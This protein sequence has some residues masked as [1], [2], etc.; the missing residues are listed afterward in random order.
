MPLFLLGDLQSVSAGTNLTGSQAPV[1][2]SA[3]PDLAAYLSPKA[4]SA[5]LPDPRP[6]AES[7]SSQGVSSASTVAT[8]VGNG[9]AS[10]V[11]IFTAPRLP[12]GFDMAKPVSPASA[13]LSSVG[14]TFASVLGF[15]N[16]AAKSAGAN[17]PSAPLAPPV[18]TALFDFDGDGKTDAANWNQSTG[19]WRVKKSSDSSVYTLTFGANASNVV[20]GD[21]DGDSVT[22]FAIFSAGTFAIKKSGSGGAQENVLL[23]AAGDTP[24][25]GDYDGD[26]KSDAAVFRP[27]TGQWLIR[28]SSTLSTVTTTFGQS[29]D[30]PVAGDYD[31]DGKTDVAVFRASAADWHVSGSTAGYFALHWGVASDMPVPAD[32]DGDDKTDFAVY[33][34]SVGSWYVYKSSTGNGEYIAQMWGNYGDQPVPAD[35]DGDGTADF[36]V[37][38]PTTGIWYVVRSSAESASEMYA[39]HTHGNASERAVPAAYLKQVGGQVFGYDMAKLRLSPKNATGGTNLYS[40]NFGWGTGLVGLPGRAGLDAGF[41][42][43]YNSLV[44]IKQGS[45]MVFD[46]DM[47]NISPG[48]RFGFATIEPVY[49]DTQTGKFSYLMVTP[50]GARVEFRQTAASG[51]YE[52]ADSSYTQLR[53]NLPENN[54]TQV[55]PEDLIMTVIGT[56]GTQMTFDWKAGAYRC[57]Q[58][59]D[60]NG[61]FITITHDEQGLLRTVKDT[62]ERVITVNYDTQLYPVSITQTWKNNNGEGSNVTHTWAS[63]TYQAEASSTKPAISTNFDSLAVYGPPNGTNLKVLK[64][65]TYSDESYTTFDYNTYGQVRQVSNFAKAGNKLNHTAVN[66]PTDASAEQPDCPRFDRTKSFVADFNN[67]QEVTFENNL[68]YGHQV[69]NSDGATVTATLVQV[70]MQDH[71]NG[72]VTNTYVGAS[73]WM[74]GLPIRTNDYASGN[75]LELVRSTWTKWTQ[76]DTNASYIQNPRVIETKVGDTVSTKKTQIDY[77]LETGSSQ[78]SRF[79]LPSEVRVYGSDQTTIQKKV[80]T[81]YKWDEA[82]L[83]RRII[84]L[85]AVSELYGLENGALILAAK[86]TYGYDEFDFINDPDLPQNITP[87][88]HD[89]ANYG[90]AFIIGRGNPTS[91]TRWDVNFHDNPGLAVKS[92]VKYDIAGSPVISIDPVGRRVIT[93]YADNF[94]EGGSRNTFAYPTSLTDPDQNSSTITYRYDMGANVRVTSPAPVGT[95]THGKITTRKYDDAGRLERQAVLVNNAEYAYTKYEHQ[96]SRIHTKVIS[97]IVDTNSNGVGD[98]ADEVTAESWTDGAGRVRRSRA[99]MQL[100]ASGN[101]TTWVGQVAVYDLAGRIAQQFVPTEIDNQWGATGDD[102]VRGWQST[103]REYDWKGRVTREI[104]LDNVDRV[105]SYDGCG[106]AGGQVTTVKGELVDGERRTQKVYADILGRTWKTEVLDYDDNVYTSTVTKYNSRDQVTWTK[107]FAGAAPGDAMNSDTCPIPGTGEQQTCQIAVSTYDGHGRL[108]TSR[109]PQQTDVTAY[110]YFKDDRPHSVIDARGASSTYRYNN[111]GLV[112]RI[113]YSLPNSANNFP[114]LGATDAPNCPNPE[115]PDCDICMI[116]PE[117][118]G[119]NEN[120]PPPGPYLS[121]AEFTYDALGNRVQMTDSESGATVYT[122]DSLSRLKTEQKQLKSAWDIPTH[123]FTISYDYN[124]SGQLS[125]VTDPFGERI[126]YGMDKVG[127]LKSIT[128]TPFGTMG[129]NNQPVTNYINGI[130][131]R[132]WGAVE[133][134]NYGN[135]T[136]MTQTFDSRLRLEQ[137]KLEKPGE[138]N[139]HLKKTYQYYNDN[140]LKFSDD[141]SGYYSTYNPER[142]DRS[143]KYDFMG[144]LTEARS[145][146]EASGGTA[147]DRSEIPYKQDYAYNAFGNVTSRQTYHWTQ[148]DNQTHTWVNQK[149]TTWGYDADGRLITTPENQYYYDAAGKAVMVSL[150]NQ[151]RMVQHLDG[152]GKPVR[153]DQYRYYSYKYNLSQTVY[154]IYSS[155][156]GKLLTEVNSNGTK[157]RTFVYGAGGVVAQQTQTVAGGQTT[158]EVRWE[159]TDPS[160]A[161]YIQT[162]TGGVRYELESPAEFDPLGSNVGTYNPYDSSNPSPD[163]SQAPG[164]GYG[165]WGDPFGGYSCMVDWV[166]Q[167]CSYAMQVLQSGAGEIGPLSQIAAWQ[168]WS[169]GKDSYWK[170]VFW[171]RGA[172]GS[173]GYYGWNNLS[174]GTGTDDDPI[175]MGETYWKPFRGDDFR[176]FLRGEWL[177]SVIKTFVED[178]LDKNPDCEN[179]INSLL[180]ELSADADLKLNGNLRYYLGEFGKTGTLEIIAGPQDGVSRTGTGGG[181]YKPSFGEPGYGFY[182]GTT[183]TFNVNGENRA[184]DYNIIGFLHEFIHLIGRRGG[185]SHFGDEQIVDTLQRL[186]ILGSDEEILESSGYLQGQMKKSGGSYFGTNVWSQYFRYVC[187]PVKRNPYPRKT[188]N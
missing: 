34:P 32:F 12:E 28:Y 83:S 144:R 79:G 45:A 134:I 175:L 60:R 8:F 111:L 81:D 43:S 132:A 115:N 11:G 143:Y 103:S 7:F 106:C 68:A 151:R 139:P 63:F 113:D 71:P 130:E 27:S 87:T 69:V 66:L 2:A 100:D 35:Y 78:V 163:Q 116:N 31:G 108:K 3:V 57:N 158:E 97:T 95:H 131:Y 91:V 20:P 93:G 74:E 162:S 180:K 85:P 153:Q 14:S 19:V 142:F 183:A 92:E 157:K 171:E 173:L 37:W 129:T 122:Y 160:N 33:R 41:G 4:V 22:D 26:G 104:G 59:K 73:G 128:G 140:R 56:D 17:Q 80:I 39:Y 16:P 40:Q 147:T 88:R 165:S 119:C 184:M 117:A 75:G 70:K 18:S 51:I 77:H 53:L 49:Y 188:K 25:V 126:D 135:G 13:F 145:G 146:I 24:M 141:A 62:L 170:P 182:L 84:G 149:E 168:E 29:G 67:D 164:W 82:Y 179:F 159:H 172:D 138:A 114:T 110:N 152:D 89:A 174:G 42:I 121:F 109:S 6:L 154:Y 38:R 137:F 161:S 54:E 52:A 185:K 90:T 118:P 86:M 156:L 107:Q 47:S 125:S 155:V 96:P 133:Q 65:I 123:N 101:T 5:L 136:Q 64:K 9:Y 167:P 15:I 23:G 176:L 72:N 48:F 112:D 30:V 55:S 1:S 177:E 166:M 94:N 61:N 120:Q 99:P 98:A 150:K 187:G 58:I 76:D 127:R 169:N 10:V 178:Y 181:L 102:A 21:Y 46:P 36:A 44:W 186:D 148:A 124:L 105:Y 50:S